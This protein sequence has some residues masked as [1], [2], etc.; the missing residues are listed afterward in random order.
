MDTLS[1]VALAGETARA[2]FDMLVD[3]INDTD[4]LRSGFFHAFKERP[5]DL[6]CVAFSRLG[7]PFR[8]S[9]F[10]VI[11]LLP[12]LSFSADIYIINPCGSHVNPRSVEWI[13]SLFFLVQIRGLW[14]VTLS[15]QCKAFSRFLWE[16]IAAL[17]EVDFYICG[18]CH[19]PSRQAQALPHF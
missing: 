4:F 10:I 18:A 3:N 14:G 11:F 5:C 17:A 6:N 2:I 9:I 8:T 1:T 15:K 7:L 16:Q 13:I 19:Y 12:L